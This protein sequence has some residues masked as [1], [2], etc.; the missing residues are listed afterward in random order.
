MILIIKHFKRKISCADSYTT[1]GPTS[2]APRFK[3]KTPGDNTCTKRMLKS[4]HKME[5]N[6]VGAISVAFAGRVILNMVMRVSE[7]NLT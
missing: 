3:P 2:E 5:R 6:N 7:F 4:S 1:K